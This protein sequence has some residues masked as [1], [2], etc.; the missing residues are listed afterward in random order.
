MATPDEALVKLRSSVAELMLAAGSGP[1][2]QS[3]PERHVAIGNLA[4]ELVRVAQGSASIDFSPVFATIE[5]L[6]RG[7]AETRNLVVV[8]ML[9]G[10]QNNSQNNGLPL[11]RWEP[12]LQPRT[13]E[14][15]TAVVDMWAGRRSP[16]DFNRL[17][18]RDED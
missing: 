1:L 14:A 12:Y 9:E 5:E 6:L 15:W 17:V 13:R 2:P 3:P 8:G 7:P 4:H 16:R 18:D 11:S 10:L